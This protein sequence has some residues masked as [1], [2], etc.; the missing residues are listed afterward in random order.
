MPAAV[1]QAARGA[2]NAKC[3]MRN[4]KLAPGGQYAPT[5][6]GFGFRISYFLLRYRRFTIAS[7]LALNSVPGFHSGQASPLATARPTRKSRRV[8]RSEEH[9]S[10]LQSLTNVVC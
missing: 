4:A 5:G 10:E 8:S 2:R 7:R 9:T 6:A 3:E 1:A